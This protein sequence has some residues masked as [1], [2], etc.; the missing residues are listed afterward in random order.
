MSAPIMSCPPWCVRRRDHD[1]QDTAGRVHWPAPFGE[2]DVTVAYDDAREL[3]RPIDPRWACEPPAY[4]LHG[5]HPDELAQKIRQYVASL[6][7]AAEW[8]ERL[9]ASL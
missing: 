2:F 7:A 9:E 6:V 4:E 3:T 8:L 1:A 5:A